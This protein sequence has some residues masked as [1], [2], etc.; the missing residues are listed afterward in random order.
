M[1]SPFPGMDPYIESSGEW[2][3]FHTSLLTAIRAKLNALLPRRYRAR[4]DLFV[5][6]QTPAS[7][8]RRRRRIEPDAYVV[9]RGKGPGMAAVVAPAAA[10][11]MITLPAVRKKHKSVL[12]IDARMDRVVTAIEI[13]SPSNKEAGEDRTA[14]LNKRGEYL[15]NG[16]NLIEID[17]LRGGPRLPLGRP[18]EVVKDYYI[19][20]CR[21]W[22]MPRASLWSFTVRDLL[23]QIPIPLVKDGPELLLPLRACIDRAYD[24]GSYDT[25]L[26][27]DGLL[28]PRLSKQDAAWVRALMAKR[29]RAEEP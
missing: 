25:E 12:I 27:Y 23:P 2:G 7:R 21:T 26:P 10:P 29:P 15:A 16:V 3:D 11:T 4:V 20:V 19:M 17:L 28:A 13:L 24:E 18:A 8:R 1:P 9:D 5:F 6:I 22:E 14:Y